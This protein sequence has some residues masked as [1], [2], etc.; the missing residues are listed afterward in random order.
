MRRT[1][2]E[3][4]KCRRI[5]PERG[6]RIPDSVVPAAVEVAE[7]YKSGILPTEVYCSVAATRFFATSFFVQRAHPN[8]SVLHNGSAIM[9]P[10]PS[11]RALRQASTTT[12]RIRPRRFSKSC[13]S[14]LDH[15]WAVY[16]NKQIVIYN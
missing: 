12:G 3:F 2:G 15:N 16:I 8:F 4:A 14:V 7:R 9:Q 13:A 5:K 1:M 6:A 11:S 10:V